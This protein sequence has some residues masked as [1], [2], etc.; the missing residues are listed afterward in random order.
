MQNK[1]SHWKGL[2]PFCSPGFIYRRKLMS[3]QL[4]F[5]LRD[6]RSF[7]SIIARFFEATT[8]CTKEIPDFTI[9]IGADKYSTT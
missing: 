5:S 2:K 1:I 9:A 8:K 6:L 3:I 4:F 7:M